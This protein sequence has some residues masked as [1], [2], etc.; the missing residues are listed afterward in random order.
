WPVTSPMP[1]V[2]SE[3]S[4]EAFPRSILIQKLLLKKLTPVKPMIWRLVPFFSNLEWNTW[5]WQDICG[6]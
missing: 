2:W 1:R 5:P 6:L 4:N 3:R